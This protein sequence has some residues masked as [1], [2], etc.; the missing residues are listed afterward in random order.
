[1]FRQNLILNLIHLSQY[2]M[3]PASSSNLRGGRWRSVELRTLKKLKMP[4]TKNVY[5]AAWFSMV[6]CGSVGSASAYCK[7]GP[8]SILGSA[9]Q[10]GLSHWAYKRWGNGERPQRMA[11][12]KCIVWMW[13]N[14]CMCVIK[15]WKINKKSGILPPK[16]KKCLRCNAA[17][18]LLKGRGGQR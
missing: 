8:S 4:L 6:R 15:I 18:T 1:M 9:P 3:V 17:K 7:A 2:S 12:D 13:L 16:L 11:R 5:G 10:G 14:E